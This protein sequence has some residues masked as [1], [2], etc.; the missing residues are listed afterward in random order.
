MGEEEVILEAARREGERWLAE[1]SF[2]GKRYEL[3][4]ASDSAGR[5]RPAGR[6][7]LAL[8][9]EGRE[10]CALLERIRAG[11]P[12]EIPRPVVAS[13][14]GS[15]LPSVHDSDWSGWSAAP[16]LKDVRVEAVEQTGDARWEAR[17]SL[18]GKAETYELEILP[19]PTLRELR[20][21][22]T[23]P[24]HEYTYD[25]T[26]LLIRM[27]NGERFALPFRLRPRWPTPPEPPS[28]TT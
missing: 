12:L 27:Q 21:P 4:V 18:D 28:L 25:L 20:A 7:P 22:T 10:V 8:T 2:R 14:T 11:E 16:R 13:G 26:R 1:L 3:A 9:L 6:S 15:R 17:L 24:F 5:L 23:P 19:G